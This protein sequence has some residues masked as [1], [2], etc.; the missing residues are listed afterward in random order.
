MGDFPY[1]KTYLLCA[2][3][4]LGFTTGALAQSTTGDYSAAAASFKQAIGDD[5]WQKLQAR[6]AA[7][8]GDISTKGIVSCYPGVPDKLLTG[9]AY[10]EFY[11][12]D[13]YFENIYLS[14]YGIAD[15]CFTNLKVFLSTASNQTDSSPAR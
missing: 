4:G 3:L 15:Y 11:D 2:L 13:L 6:L 9:Y 5:D 8:N 12:W 14:Y 7:L 1:M 10:D